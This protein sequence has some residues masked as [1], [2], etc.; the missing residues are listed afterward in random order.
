MG[1][2]FVKS[3]G[4]ASNFLAP[5]KRNFK[6]MEEQIHYSY[7]RPHY[8]WANNYVHG[9]SKGFLFKAGTFKQE[10]VMLAGPSNYGLADPGQNTAYSL[11]QT[12]LT[13]IGFET[14]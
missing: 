5:G 10:H 1:V 14:H 4:W 12:T 6:G 7:M 11:F 9:G 3:Y 13:L 8:K 2:D